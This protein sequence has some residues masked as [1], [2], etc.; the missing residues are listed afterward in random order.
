MKQ[1]IHFLI[2]H[3]K[4]ELRAAARHVII[5][6]RLIFERLSAFCALRLHGRV[7]RECFCVVSL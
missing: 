6:G 4:Q 3:L 2:H 7:Y 1:F 5:Q